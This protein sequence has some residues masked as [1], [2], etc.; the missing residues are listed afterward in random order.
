MHK[1]RDM[2]GVFIG[3][4]TGQDCAVPRSGDGEDGRCLLHDVSAGMGM[5]VDAPLLPVADADVCRLPG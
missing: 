3:V 1:I 4:R 5:G 2:V